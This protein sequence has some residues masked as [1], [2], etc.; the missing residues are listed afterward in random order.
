MEWIAVSSLLQVLVSAPRTLPLSLAGDWSV[1]VSAGS[2]E[3]DGRTFT[4]GEDTTLS[5]D[6]A[7]IVTVVDEKCEGLPVFNAQ[8][9]PFWQGRAL[10]GVFTQETAAAGAYEPGSLTVKAAP[11][12]AEA[13][14]EGT[15]Y[16][17]GPDWGVIG[18]VEGGAIAEGQAVYLSYRHGVCRI[19]SIAVDAQGRL[20]VVRGAPHINN[21]RQPELPEGTA[22]LANIWLPWRTAALSDDCLLPIETDGYPEPAVESPTPAEVL[23]PRAVEKL[24]SG[25]KL[26]ILAWGDSVTVGTYVPNW[27]QNRWQ[28]QFVAQL[29][30]RFPQ[31][32]IE[33]QTNAWGGRNVQSFLAEPPG[34]EYN[35][36]EQVLGRKPD[37]I[38]SEFVNDAYL[39]PAGVET[40]Y[41]KLLGDFQGIG[42]EWIILTPHY[43]RPD[44][45]ALTSQKNCDADP[46][47]YVQGLREFAPRH[48]VALADASLRWGHLWREGIPYMTY[49]MNTINHPDERGMKLFADSIMALFPGK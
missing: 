36:E 40:L 15:D 14:V 17:I 4:V 32:D 38:V 25:E 5:I 30:A 6:P 20:S 7:E 11:D 19:D 33:L 3:V 49:L 22:R 16:A 31:A 18:R 10:P 47:A 34:S 42:A 1:R 37:L 24:R 43:V 41:S 44:W 27:E 8:A 48:S 12:A 23:V 9:A 29:R 45:M 39:D 35:Y 46:R 26:R 2:V 28:E 13:L 21:P